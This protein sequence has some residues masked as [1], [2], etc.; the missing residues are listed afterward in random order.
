MYR[1]GHYGAALLTYAPVGAALLV[2]GFGAAAVAGGAG[3]LALARVPDYDLRVPLVSHRGPTHTLA[4]ALLVGTVLGGALGALAGTAA[5]GRAVAL[6]AFGFVVGVLAVGSHLLADAL[7][8]AGVEPFW[9]LS[10]KNYSLDLVGADSTIGNYG[11]LALGVFVS[12]TTLL[13]GGQLEQVPVL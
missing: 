6:G 10:S 3:V 5:P 1:T 8:P 7:T 11:L 12:A 4:F 2:A 9:P 13:L